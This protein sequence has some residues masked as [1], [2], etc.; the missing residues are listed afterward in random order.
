MN[1][2]DIAFPNLGIYLENV[3]K[4]FSVFG[5][6]I[7]FYGLIIGIGVMAGI[8]LATREAKRTGQN[9]DDYWD[10]AIYAII[11][12]IVGA[13]LYYVIFSWDNYKNDLSSIFAIWQGGLAIYGAVIAAFLTLLVYT[14]VKKKSFWQMADTAVPGLVLGQIIGRWGN[15]MNREAFGD[16]SDGLLAMALPIDAVRQ[17]EIT[18]NHWAHVAEGANYIMVHPTFLYE[19]LWN[20]GVLTVLLLY[21]KH[22]KFEGEISLMY[23]AGYGIGRFFIEGLRTDQLLLPVIGLPVSQL[24][25]I[26]AFLVC[27]IIIIV[28]RIYKKKEKSV[29]GESVSLADNQKLG[30]DK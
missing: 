26:V 8:L 28:L 19:S 21:R 24:L 3:P 27:T 18:A 5:F 29:F 6:H 20:L 10:F 14:K 30:R 4:N 22:K 15:F 13:R 12:S 11:F 16:Y 7:A 25:G 23:L 17:H 9:P 1:S 2:T